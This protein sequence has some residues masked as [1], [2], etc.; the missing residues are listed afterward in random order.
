MNSI[1]VS[2]IKLEVY[3]IT[4]IGDAIN[5]LGIQDIISWLSLLNLGRL[6]LTCNPDIGDENVTT[7]VQL[8]TLTGTV[9]FKNA[10]K[11]PGH[12]LTVDTTPL[13]GAIGTMV[14]VDGTVVV[15]VV[16]TGVVEYSVSV[17]QVPGK[18]FI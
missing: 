14:V 6:D 3:V 8:V 13:Q 12:K 2:V 5:W 10:I 15:E 16:V 17:E 9:T 11:L 4:C 1:V 7:I 18:A